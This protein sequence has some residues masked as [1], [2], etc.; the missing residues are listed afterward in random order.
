[1]HLVRK[2][3]GHS[4]QLLPV[5][6]LFIFV[7]AR[8]K[9]KLA[10][11]WYYVWVISY[12]CL[13]DESPIAPRGKNMPRTAH[14]QSTGSPRTV[15]RTPMRSSWAT[16]GHSTGR[17]RAAFGQSTDRPNTAYRHPTGSPRA[18]HR[19]TEDSP[20]AVYE[21]PTDGPRAAN[22]QNKINSRVAQALPVDSSRA[23]HG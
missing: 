21:K 7:V 10:A 11:T 13:F 2:C 22:V 1:M 16:H 9:T 4:I 17:P 20:R 14:E 19:Q 23:A 8:T 12:I 6:L 18:A 3:H 5:V 15:R